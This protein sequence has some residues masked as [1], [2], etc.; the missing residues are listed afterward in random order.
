MP[1]GVIFRATPDVP[2]CGNVKVLFPA[3]DIQVQICAS[4]TLIDI[5]ASLPIGA[6]EGVSTTVES[7]NPPARVNGNLSELVETIATSPEI[8]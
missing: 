5:V 3:G 6:E 8:T 2:P 7:S 1:T 4:L